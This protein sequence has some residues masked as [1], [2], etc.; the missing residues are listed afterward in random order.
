MEALRAAGFT[1]VTVDDCNRLFS[2]FAP[3]A[4][5]ANFLA[6]YGEPLPEHFFRDQIANSLPLF[7]ARLQTLTSAT[8]LKLH[9]EGRTMCV[10]SGSPRTRVDACLEVALIDGCFASAYSAGAGGPSKI[11]TREDV[12]KGKPDPEMF[13]LAAASLGVAPSDCVVV[14]DST[15]GIRAAIAANMEVVGFLGGGHAQAAWY[16]DSLAAFG[17]PLVYSQ[18]GLY[19]F[20]AAR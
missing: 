15:A 10:A 17:I 2:G 3:E 14:E 19:E 5:A 16:R 1:G 6:E 11:F 8:V 18:E 20:L 7:R 12:T 4:G 13:L 9:A